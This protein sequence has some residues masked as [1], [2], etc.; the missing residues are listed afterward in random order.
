MG[1]SPYL[2][3]LPTTDTLSPPQL[4]VCA[5]LRRGVVLTSR[6][7]PLVPLDL[8][9]F[10]YVIGMDEKNTRAIKVSWGVIWYWCALLL[11]LSRPPSPPHTALSPPTGSWCAL[12]FLLPPSLYS[13]PHTALVRTGRLHASASSHCTVPPPGSRSA[14]VFLSR[15]S[16]LHAPDGNH[17]LSVSAVMGVDMNIPRCGPFLIIFRQARK[18]AVAGLGSL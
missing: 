10:D 8:A 12:L 15:T 7:R 5:A 11:S 2:L 9:R 3:V 14:L 4:T 17:G 1:L 13:L 18:F 16:R 6:S